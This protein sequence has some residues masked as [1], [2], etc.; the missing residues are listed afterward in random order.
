MRRLCDYTGRVSG[1]RSGNSHD[2]CASAAQGQTRQVFEA[3]L[4]DFN[5]GCIS[6][7]L[8]K[9]SVGEA[10]ILARLG[11]DLLGKC[12]RGVKNLW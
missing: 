5:N 1:R 2:R 4:N 6:W 9:Y 10:V 3:G 8:I 11:F 12:A 7:F